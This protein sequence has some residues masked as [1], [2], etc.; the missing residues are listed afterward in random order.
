M[1]ACIAAGARLPARRAPWRRRTASRSP[2]R[3]RSPRS[4]S[5]SV[6]RDRWQLAAL[7]RRWPC[8]ALFL[9]VDLAFFGANIVKIADG[10]W[11]PLVVGAGHLPLMTTWKRGRQHRRRRM[12]SDSSLPMDLFLERH[13][14]AQAAARAGHRRVHDLEPRPGAPVVLLHHL[15]H[16]KVL[17]EKVVLHVD[18]GRGDPAGPGRG[19]GRRWRTLGDG[20]YKVIGRYGFMETP[21]VPALLASRRARRAS[22]RGRR[23]P[24]STWA[25]RRCFRTARPMPRWRKAAVHRHGAER[26][27][28]HRLLQSAAQPGARAGRA[29]SAVACRAASYPRRRFCSRISRSAT[30]A[31]ALRCWVPSVSD[32]LTFDLVPLA[33]VSPFSRAQP[34]RSLRRGV[35]SL[36]KSTPGAIRG[37]KTRGLTC[38]VVR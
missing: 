17:H 20:F 6:A 14:A 23:R 13:R 33:P 24:A 38:S 7:A 15:K 35:H 30:Q 4:C 11:F 28:G 31:V 9:V 21:D 25:G 26:P 22:A 27:V 37:R 32:L 36:D 8:G 34:Q 16:N 3:W 10:G 18:R 1:V 19:A 2:A 29:D 5:T 12:L